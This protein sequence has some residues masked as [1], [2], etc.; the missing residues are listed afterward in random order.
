[1]GEQKFS[2]NNLVVILDRSGSMA[3][4]ADEVIG[5]FNRLLLEQAAANPKLTVTLAQFDDVYEVSYVR[6]PV[7]HL[8]PLDRW[9]YCP[10]GLT[11]LYDAVGRTIAEWWK[12]AKGDILVIVTDGEDNSSKEYKKAA[13]AK[14]LEAIQ[15]LGAQVLFLAANF[16]AFAEAG[17]LNIGS[18]STIGYHDTK[19]LSMNF[20]DTVSQAIANYQVT[21]TASVGQSGASDLGGG[22]S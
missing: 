12:W 18:N 15:T 7:A 14:Q 17:S 13:V 6:V 19:V 4:A 2:V 8:K 21:G 16:D 5:S 9:S 20:G 3:M 11:A 1:M 10:R 22:N